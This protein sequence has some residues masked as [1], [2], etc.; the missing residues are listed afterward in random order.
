[1]EL[2]NGHALNEWAT[3][4]LYAHREEMVVEEDGGFGSTR[5]RGTASGRRLL[6]TEKTA[7]Y[8]AKNRLDDLP[9]VIEMPRDAANFWAVVNGTTNAQAKGTA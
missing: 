9:S 6:G 1:M 2:F 8:D 3:E 4:V 5:K 7:G